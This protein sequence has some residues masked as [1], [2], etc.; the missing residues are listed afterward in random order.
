MKKILEH[1][2]KLLKPKGRTFH[3]FIVSKH[4][5][6]QFVDAKDTGTRKYFPGGRV[7]PFAAIIGQNAEFDLV[8]SWY[9][10]G[11]NYWRT[12]DEWHRRF[13]HNIDQIYDRVLGEDGVRH[14]NDYFSYSKT[15]FAPADGQV[16]GNGQYLFQLK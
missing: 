8:E 2:S 16:T 3:H 6:P 10:N 11:L 1:I 13:W 4:V 5:I 9:I 7:W 14:W 12:V 15:L